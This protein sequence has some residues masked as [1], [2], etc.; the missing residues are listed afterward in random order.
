MAQVMWVKWSGCTPWVSWIDWWRWI[1]RCTCR[2]SGQLECSW[3][4]TTLMYLGHVWTKFFMKGPANRET[5]FPTIFQDRRWLFQSL[6][7][8]ETGWA[9]V[10]VRLKALSVGISNLGPEEQVV[11]FGWF[12]NDFYE[13][14]DYF[15]RTFADR[16]SPFLWFWRPQQ[17]YLHC[18]MYLCYD[19]NL[20]VADIQ[21]NI[22]VWLLT[23]LGLSFFIGRL[24]LTQLCRGNECDTYIYTRPCL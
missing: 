14:L 5:Y 8:L 7:Q 3:C 24:C 15:S 16:M 2:T 23:L 9:E 4:S 11:N 6:W 22:Q 10:E 19:L 21:S 1:Q 17:R 13:G 18:G 20:I 12:D